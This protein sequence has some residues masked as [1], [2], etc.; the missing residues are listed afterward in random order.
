L[1]RGTELFESSFAIGASSAAHLIVHAYPVTRPE[2]LDS[3]ARKGDGAGYFMAEGQRQWPHTRK[4]SAV[5]DVGS[6]DSCRNDINHHI[7][8]SR[9]G[10]VD[11]TLL[12]G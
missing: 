1:A 11:V 12:Q 7:G 5:V 3:G 4:P 8:R 9:L 2:V 10:T 6:T